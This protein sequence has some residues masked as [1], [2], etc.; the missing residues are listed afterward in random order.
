MVVLSLEEYARLTDGVEATLDKADR[1]A[2][3]DAAR[4]MRMF[5]GNCGGK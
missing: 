3:E 5:L 1:L 4:M 2:A